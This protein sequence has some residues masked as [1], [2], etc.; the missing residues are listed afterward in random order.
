MSTSRLR[1][2]PLLLA[3]SLVLLAGCSSMSPAE[4]ALQHE[5]ALHDRAEQRVSQREAQQQATIDSLPAWVIKRPTPD[6][7]GLYGVGVGSSQS[8]SLALQKANID[9]RRDMAQEINQE[10]SAETTMTGDSDAAFQGIVN[11]FINRVD[12]AGAED[13]ERVIQS[14][15]D[16]YRVYTLLKLPYPEFNRAL[17]EFSRENEHGASTM[18]AQY[19][20]LMDRAASAPTFAPEPQSGAAREVAPVGA[21]MPDEALVRA[22]QQR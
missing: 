19:E 2:A 5:Q 14:G 8:L 21:D 13:V 22:L 1:T 7:T 18:Q 4:Q 9:A 10:L 15:R 11:T 6:A 20:R 17:T 3:G 16:G 12:V